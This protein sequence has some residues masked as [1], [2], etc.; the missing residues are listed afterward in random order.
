MENQTAEMYAEVCKPK[1]LATQ[2]LDEVSRQEC[3]ELD[4]FVVFSSFSCWPWSSLAIQW[5]PIGEVGAFHESMHTETQ[6]F[7]LMPQ[8]INSCLAVM[9][10]FLS[11]KQPVVSCFVKSTKSSTQDSGEKRNL[12]ESVAR[13]LGE[14]AWPFA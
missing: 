11:Q 9:D 12:V 2:S 6:F 10:Y 4:H 13:I 14:F 5:G 7:G 3:P 1:V 8:P